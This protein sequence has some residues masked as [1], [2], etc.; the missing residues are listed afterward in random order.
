MNKIRINVQCP[1]CKCDMLCEIDNLGKTLDRIKFSDKCEVCGGTMDFTINAIAEPFCVN[2][3]IEILQSKISENEKELDALYKACAPEIETE[4]LFRKTQHL[5]DSLIDWLIS[6]D[7]KINSCI[8]LDENVGRQKV[9]LIEKKHTQVT[10]YIG[11]TFKSYDEAYL[12]LKNQI[13]SENLEVE[14]A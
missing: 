1:T 12:W 13:K 10:T 7:Y 11:Y 5:K 9:W 14:N 3:S 6:R 4:P 2:K 8:S